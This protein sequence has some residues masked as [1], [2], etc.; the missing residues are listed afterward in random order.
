M[1]QENTSE[2]F[3]LGNEVPVGVFGF[4]SLHHLWAGSR[5][6]RKKSFHIRATLQIAERREGVRCPLGGIEHE[7]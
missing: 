2:E 5:E 6:R 3:D 7:A 4:R 1:P